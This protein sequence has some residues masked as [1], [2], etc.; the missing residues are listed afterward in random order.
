MHFPLLGPEITCKE[1]IY[2]Q[3]ERGQKKEDM[4]ICGGKKIPLSLDLV[5][6][7]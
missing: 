6:S 5:P 2:M 1:S 7:S 4:N 3:T